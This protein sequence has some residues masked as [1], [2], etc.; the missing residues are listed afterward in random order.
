M[1]VNAQRRA[2]NVVDPPPDFGPKEQHK[3]NRWL[4]G[5]GKEGKVRSER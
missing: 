4:I 1:F 3:T 2:A 5:E